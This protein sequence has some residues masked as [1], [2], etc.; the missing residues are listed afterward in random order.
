MAW[1][2]RSY[3]HIN[4]GVSEHSVRYAAV[5]SGNVVKRE[6]ASRVGDMH[7][8]A[9]FIAAAIATAQQSLQT[10]RLSLEKCASF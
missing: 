5:T 1:L 2:S 7:L 3:E 4:H 9:T 6:R 8:C 10:G